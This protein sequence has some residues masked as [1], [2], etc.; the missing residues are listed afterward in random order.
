V[1]RIAT[2]TLDLEQAAIVELARR[3]SR[4]RGGVM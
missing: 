1:G 4:G 2:L 3:G